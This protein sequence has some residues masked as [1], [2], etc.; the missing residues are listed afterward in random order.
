[1]NVVRKKPVHCARYNGIPAR[2]VRE[3]QKRVGGVRWPVARFKRML[4]ATGAKSNWAE[5]GPHC[6]M[7]TKITKIRT[8]R[9][10]LGKCHGLTRRIVGW[11]GVGRANLQQ[12]A[13]TRTRNVI[14]PEHDINTW[15]G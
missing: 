12:L 14:H 5:P 15:I 10:A 1:M 11:D 6:A 4:R 13:R 8:V 9:A 2:H 3:T 7:N